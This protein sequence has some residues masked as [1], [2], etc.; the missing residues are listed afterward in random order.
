MAKWEKVV[1]F[2]RHFYFAACEV[3]LEQTVIQA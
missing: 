2:E 1:G 3:V